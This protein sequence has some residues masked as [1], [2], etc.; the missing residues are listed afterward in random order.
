MVKLKIGVVPYMNAKPLIYGLI[1]QSDKIDLLYGAP[2]TLPEKLERGELDII[3]MP[4][5]NY[6]RGNG[7]KII[8]GSSIS[9][10]GPVESVN[11]FIKTPTIE[12]IRVVA[13]DKDS[14]TSC[15]LT[16]IILWKRY[17]MKPEFIKLKDKSK[18][19][20]EY[21]DAFLVIGDDALKLQG[22]DFTVLDLGQ[23]WKELTGLPFVYA[24]WVA[25][26]K[27]KL[28]GVERLLNDAKEHGLKSLNKIACLEAERLKLGRYRCLR[29]LEESIRYDLGEQEIR[30]LKS[31]YKYALEMGEVSEKIKIKFHSECYR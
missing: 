15:V 14:L 25:K 16:K 24:F 12:K 29:Y 21:A 13:L 18:I 10:S 7:Y 5:V 30:G 1:K 26:S 17:S 3:L 23:E 8:P 4:S 20:N 27:S 11:L 2:S 19:Y 22:E 9:S 31:F 28:H 6:F